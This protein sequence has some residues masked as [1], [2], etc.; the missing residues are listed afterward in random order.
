[1]ATPEQNNNNASEVSRC[2][3]LTF[4]QDDRALQLMT[5]MQAKYS[6]L[7]REKDAQHRTA[8]AELDRREFVRIHGQEPPPFFFNR[9]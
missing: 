7:I 5:E 8:M 1:M 6:A 9:Y 2:Q 4:R 3:T